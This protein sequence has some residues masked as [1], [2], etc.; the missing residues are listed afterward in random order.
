[1]NE[2]KTGAKAACTGGAEEGMRE[3]GRAARARD[4]A[5]IRAAGA[6]VRWGREAPK[7]P[8][9]CLSWAPLDPGLLLLLEWSQARIAFWEL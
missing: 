6:G 7:M 9:S 1:M 2:T 4:A 5:G 8:P 3:A